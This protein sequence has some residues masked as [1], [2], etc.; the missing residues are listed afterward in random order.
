MA[1]DQKRHVRSIPR[2]PEARHHTGRFANNPDRRQLNASFG[3][4]ITTL[5]TELARHDHTREDPLL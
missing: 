4:F 2:P 3:Q 5:A 1:R